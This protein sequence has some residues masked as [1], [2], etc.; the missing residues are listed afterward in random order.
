MFPYHAV[1]FDLDGTLVN[2]LADIADAMN[3]VLADND[4]PTHQEGTYKVF[5]GD[6][7]R[8]LVVRSLPEA[9]RTRETVDRYFNNM[10]E[11]Y[12]QS[13]TRK[14]HLY[15]GIPALLDELSKRGIKMS[16]LSNKADFFTQKVVEKLLGNWKFELVMGAGEQFPRKPDPA[17]ALFMAESMRVSANKILYL[18]DTD[19]DMITATAAGFTAIGVSWGFRKKEELLAHG[20]KRVIDIPI[21]LLE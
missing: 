19:T 11:E 12:R 4:F 5:V 16:I 21:Q 7:I 9:A 8:N 14:T 3:K 10:L 20:A 18:G 2:S 13:F 6:G 1:I 15:E 17:A